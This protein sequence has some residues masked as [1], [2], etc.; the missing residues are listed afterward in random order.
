MAK[1]ADRK[2]IA[3][4]QLSV[5]RRE[6]NFVIARGFLQVASEIQRLD[7]L[8]HDPGGHGIRGVSEE[9]LAETAEAEEVGILLQNGGAVPACAEKRLGGARMQPEGAR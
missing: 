5:G 4:R 2:G 1:R 8:L 9:R 7:G 3:G 6:Q